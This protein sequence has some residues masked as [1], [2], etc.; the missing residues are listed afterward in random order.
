MVLEAANKIPT[1]ISALSHVKSIKEKIDDEKKM[2]LPL[3]IF[4]FFKIKENVLKSNLNPSLF[5]KSV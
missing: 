1:T 4:L 2:I 3:K 5:Q